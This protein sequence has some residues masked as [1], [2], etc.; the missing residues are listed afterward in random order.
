[1]MKELTPENVEEATVFMEPVRF[2]KEQCME[3]IQSLLTNNGY[4]LMIVAIG[5]RTGA[6]VPLLD[7]MPSTHTPIVDIIE[8]QQK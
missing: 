3:Q 7:F 1:M 4:T 6:H 8:A 2:T 5:N